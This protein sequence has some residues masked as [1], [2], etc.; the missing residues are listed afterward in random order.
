MTTESRRYSLVDMDAAET[1]DP[2]LDV[3][4]F[5][6]DNAL[7]LPTAMEIVEMK[8]GAL[9]MFGGGAAPLYAVRREE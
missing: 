3:Q 1:I 9:V 2:N 8:P 5:I 6:L 7:D 4:A